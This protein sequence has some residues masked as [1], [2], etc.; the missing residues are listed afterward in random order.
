MGKLRVTKLEVFKKKYNNIQNVS[1]LFEQQNSIKT[2]F[3]QANYKVTNLIASKTKPLSEGDF[4]K[5]CILTVF[6]EIIPKN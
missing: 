5:K 3:I 2:N 4:I 1:N 6:E